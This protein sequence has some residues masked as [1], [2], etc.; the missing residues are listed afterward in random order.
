MILTDQLK[1]SDNMIKANQGKYDLDR[2]AAK[3]S[4]YPFW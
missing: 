1:I 3:I 4:A 2:S